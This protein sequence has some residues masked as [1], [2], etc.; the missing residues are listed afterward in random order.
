[1]T[2]ACAL[3]SMRTITRIFIAAAVALLALPQVTF[4][5]SKTL[6]AFVSKVSASLVS[7]DYSF[8]MPSKKAKMTGNGSVKVQGTS[9]IVDGNGL[10]IWCDGVTR[11]TIDRISEE[12]LVESVDESYD[13]YATNPALMIASIDNAFREV[14][15]GSSKFRGTVV[16][17]S[18]LSPVHKGKGSMDIAGLKLFFKSG[19]TTLT[20]AE[21][22]LNDGSVSD[23]TITNLKFVEAG[24]SKE[25]FRFDEKTLDSSYVV[26]DLR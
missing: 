26:T 10:E 18:V 22:T 23:F 20:G 4:A 19:T 9:F 21:V 14:S 3:K 17:T 11:W 25:S 15:F 13:S 5:K 2:C 1:M 6:D 7:F 8:T 12:A 16:D 24:K